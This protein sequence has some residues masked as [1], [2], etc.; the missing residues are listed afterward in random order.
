MC[1]LVL[2]LWEVPAVLLDSSL[3][4]T[5]QFGEC[6]LVR[7]VQEWEMGRD[8]SSLPAA[9]CEPRRAF[10]HDLICILKESFGSNRRTDWMQ[11]RVEEGSLWGMG[12]SILKL[13]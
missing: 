6:C 11:A 13:L 12:S 10:Q 3:F 9:K 4:A 1:E 8:S 2:D 5:A 7:P